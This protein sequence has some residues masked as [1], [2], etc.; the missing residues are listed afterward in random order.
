MKRKIALDL[1]QNQQ[2]WVEVEEEA[3]FNE[4]SVS[5]GKPEYYRRSRELG[6][7][8]EVIG[9]LVE[10]ITAPLKALEDQP[11]E[12]NLHFAFKFSAQADV[13]L[14]PYDSESLVK[15]HLKWKPEQNV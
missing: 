11:Q 1:G 6:E 12:I 4:D 2:V 14:T 13:L 9:P 3:N 15:V 5:S 7:A 10:K 8:V